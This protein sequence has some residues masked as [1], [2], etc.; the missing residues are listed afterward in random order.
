MMTPTRF[1]ASQINSAVN[2][3]I[4]VALQPRGEL[5]RLRDRSRTRDGGV[6]PPDIPDRKKLKERD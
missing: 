2:I 1:F 4:A 6:V 5:G 3:Q